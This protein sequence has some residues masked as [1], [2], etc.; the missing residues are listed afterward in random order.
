M[1]VNKWYMKNS[2]FI[3]LKSL[4]PCFIVA[5]VGLFK[6]FFGIFFR[7]LSLNGLPMIGLPATSTATENFPEIAGVYEIE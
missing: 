5:A 1:A 2:V 3:V 4:L 6:L 7:I